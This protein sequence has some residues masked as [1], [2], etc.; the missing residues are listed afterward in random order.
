MCCFLAVL[1]MIG[2]R[3]AILVWWL[4]QPVRWEAA[5]TSFF[6]PFLGFIFAPWTTMSYVLVAPGGVV[7]FDWVIIGLAV[8]I[9]IASYVSGPYSRRD[10]YGYGY[11]A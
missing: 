5:F 4:L 11:S 7:F 9:D 8:M 10:Q 2:P 3:A 6:V 1:V